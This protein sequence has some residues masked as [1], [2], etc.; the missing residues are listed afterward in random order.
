MT[1]KSVRNPRHKRG[2][3]AECPVCGAEVIGPAVY[4]SNACKQKAYRIRNQNL[5]TP[6]IGIR[7]AEPVLEME[8]TNET[9]RPEVNRPD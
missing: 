8:G 5:E 1:R 4:D 3:V 6:G 2:E 9:G 7:I